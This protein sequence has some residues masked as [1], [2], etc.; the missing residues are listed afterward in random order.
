MYKVLH[1]FIITERQFI[2]FILYYMCNMYF[3]SV[4]YKLYMVE[5]HYKCLIFIR[6]DIHSV[7]YSFSQK[8]YQYLRSPHG[9]WAFSADPLMCFYTL[10]PSC[11]SPSLAENYQICRFM[12]DCPSAR[13]A[14]FCSVF[15]LLDKLQ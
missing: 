1:H 15:R 12:A 14:S 6:P 7:R 5:E 10:S 2:C 11:G 9:S 4:I 3:F 8:S 13:T